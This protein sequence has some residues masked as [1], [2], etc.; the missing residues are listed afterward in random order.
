MKNAIIYA[1]YSSERQTEQSIESQLRV[2][3]EYAQRNGLN[4]VDS[5]IDKAMTGTN[6]NRP[7]FQRMLLDAEKSKAW[8]IVLVYAI[9]RFGRNSIEIAVN[10]QKL[11]KNGKTLI[12]ATQRTSEN[13]DGTKNLDGILL[14]NVYIGMNQYY[15]AELSQKVL[16]GLNESYRKGQYTGGAVIYGY[17]VVDKKNVINPE[18]AEIVKEIF[19]K[20]SQGYTAV[21]LAKD[22]QARGIRTKKGLYI[23]D[24][25]IYKILANT[26]YNGKIR[27]GDTI[28]DNIYPKIIDD[29]TWQKVQDIHAENQHAPGRK[30]EIYD[31][32]LSGKLYCGDCQRPMVGESGTSKLGRIYYYYSCLA[33]RRKQHPC[34]LKSVEKQWLEDLVINS[35]WA[36]LADEGV[37]RHIAETL[38]KL[39]EEENKNNTVI[40]SLEAQRQN[41]LKAS[42]N[43]IAAIEQ[44]II[45][46]QT[47]IRLKELE[48]QIAGLDFDIGQEKQRNYTYLSPDD[49][50]KYLNSIIC[51]DIQEMSVRKLIVKTFVREVILD[52]DSV[53]ITYNFTE[54]S[55]KYR[56]TQEIVQKIQRQSRKKTAY[57]KT[58]CSYKLPSLP[59]NKT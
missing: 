50:E 27:H 5:Y 45:T 4:V 51:G 41:A 47:K 18:E 24:K 28:Y 2:C 55:T 56:V 49:V 15:S 38:C 40:K 11:K 30:K 48:S 37:V 14:E 39:H 7:S 59:P 13:I 3:N 9:D 43:L 21:A 33:K 23:T 10:K 32:I 42:Q 19:T 52:N 31:F 8:D 36:L 54:H 34:K 58:V 29:I 44:G 53:T 20:Y 46:E 26:K 22:L 57:N 1:R 6:D 16:R 35:T 12:S 17:D 25:K